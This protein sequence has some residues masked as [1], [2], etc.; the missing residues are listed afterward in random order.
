MLR[1]ASMA[2][3]VPPE[4]LE[5]ED[6]HHISLSLDSEMLKG[7]DEM[8]KVIVF[9]V[10]KAREGWM[11][12]QRISTMMRELADPEWE[13]ETT[14]LK[15]G[16]FLTLCPSQDTVSNLANQNV[17]ETQQCSLCCSPWTPDLWRPLEADGETR[18]VSLQQLP[19]FCRHRESVSRILKPLGELIHVDGRGNRYTDDVRAALRIRYGKTL[20]CIIACSVGSRKHIIRVVQERGQLSLP[21]GRRRTGKRKRGSMGSKIQPTG[22]AKKTAEMECP[23]RFSREE[24]GKGI[25]RDMSEKPNWNRPEMVAGKQKGVV[26][27][28]RTEEQLGPAVK[29]HLRED[30]PSRPLS[31]RR[32]MAPEGQKRCQPLS[33]AAAP[34]REVTAIPLT[35]QGHVSTPEWSY[36]DD[37]PKSGVATKGPKGSKNRSIEDTELE[38]LQ[39]T[40]QTGQRT[41]EKAQGEKGPAYQ[42]NADAAEANPNQPLDSTGTSSTLTQPNPVHNPLSRE[43]SPSRPENTRPRLPQLELYPVHAPMD[44]AQP[45]VTTLTTAAVLVQQAKCPQNTIIANTGQEGEPGPISN[46]AE[47]ELMINLKPIN[48][49]SNGQKSLNLDGES[50][51]GKIKLQLIN[52]PWRL[53]P[54]DEWMAIMVSKTQPRSQENVLPPLGNEVSSA[55]QGTQPPNQTTQQKPQKKEKVKSPQMINQDPGAD[56]ESR[57]TNKAVT[58][59]KKK[60][61]KWTPPLSLRFR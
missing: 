18:W 1:A 49:Y 52:G 43:P 41:H 22:E 16:R 35:A 26:I 47:L 50:T 6:I 11:D 59:P 32:T 24:K 54:N 34:T 7:K 30:Q 17:I 21:W 20:P 36:V 42:L 61:L 5:E 44:Q 55:E 58:I 2:P 40:G 60:A 39:W 4:E 51:S 38:G 9:T 57:A 25:A 19:H 46:V 37:I 53:I 3:E 29:G 56:L 15:D 14:E 12:A 8:K 28:E 10:E 13:W 27:R 33:T 23:Q 48:P 45:E 31:D